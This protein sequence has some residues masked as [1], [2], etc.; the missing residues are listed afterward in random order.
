MRRSAVWAAVLL[1]GCTGYGEK[2]KTG[3]AVVVYGRGEFVGGIVEDADTASFKWVK[4]DV[5][6]NGVYLDPGH[7]FRMEHEHPL[8][9]RVRMTTGRH[10]GEYVF[11]RPVNLAAVP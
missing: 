6:D 11:L 4:L 1:A 7:A 9:C 3:A 2:L 5:G 10:A 8:R